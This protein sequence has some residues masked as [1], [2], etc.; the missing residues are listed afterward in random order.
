MSEPRRKL[1]EISVRRHSFGR[2]GA[3]DSHEA[4]TTFEWANLS[5]LGGGAGTVR[6]TLDAGDVSG[7][8]VPERATLALVALGAVGMVTVR[9]RSH[10]R[11]RLGIH[12]GTPL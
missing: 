6:L 9:W 8:G 2:A 12:D 11:H 4:R 3:P 5:A 1:F 10:G 7:G